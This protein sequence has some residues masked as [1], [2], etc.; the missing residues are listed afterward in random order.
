MSNF[1]IGSEISF[2]IESVDNPPVRGKDDNVV[3]ALNPGKGFE[4]LEYIHNSKKWISWIR[5][6]LDVKPTLW[7]KRVK[8][9][10]Y[11]EGHNCPCG[12][13]CYPLTEPGIFRCGKCF[14]ITKK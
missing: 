2:T 3:I 13:Y 7:L 11:D 9:I 4:S 5:N 10:K 12:G 14:S 8:T 1:E 6:D